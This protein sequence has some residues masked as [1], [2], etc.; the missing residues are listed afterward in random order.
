MELNFKDGGLLPA[1]VQD[2]GSGK[3]RWQ[4]K[5]DLSALIGKPLKLYFR[6]RGT[7][8]YAFHFASE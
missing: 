6:M 4:G 2:A 5:P 7:R 8:L 1:V 3:V